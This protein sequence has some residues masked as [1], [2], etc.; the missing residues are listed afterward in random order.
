MRHSAA[1]V[2]LMCLPAL[3]GNR[4]EL[5]T[6]ERIIESSLKAAG[7]DRQ[8]AK[9]QRDNQSCQVVRTE[10]VGLFDE[11]GCKLT[12]TQVGS[13]SQACVADG[14]S[15]KSTTLSE[16]DNKYVVNLKD[17]DPDAVRFRVRKRETLNDFP[18]TEGEMSFEVSFA[19]RQHIKAIAWSSTNKFTASTG[20][21]SPD[22]R[23]DRQ[24]GVADRFA[25]T[26]SSQAEGNR[27]VEELPRAIGLCAG[28]KGR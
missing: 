11:M 26:M 15:N 6:T 12:F 20:K 3:A 13:D 19:T 24:N 8:S 22:T 23:S 21:H 14:D 10:D 7:H 16:W 17:L 5:Q 28:K 18:L 2:L 4:E 1:V 25:F 27:M 9:G